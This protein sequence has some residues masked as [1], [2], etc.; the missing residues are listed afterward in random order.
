MMKITIYLIVENFFVINYY[1][2]NASK[3]D[4]HIRTM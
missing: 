2:T 4:E 1:L 3:D